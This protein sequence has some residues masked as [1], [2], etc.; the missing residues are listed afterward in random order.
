MP[1][2][3]KIQ[4]QISYDLKELQLE[5]IEKGLMRDLEKSF[6]LQ[7]IDYAWKGNDHKYLKVANFI[8]GMSTL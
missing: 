3:L 2:F 4:F 1:T 7:Q 8:L 5:I 6:L